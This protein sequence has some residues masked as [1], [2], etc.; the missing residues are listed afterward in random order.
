M[1]K[2]MNLITEEVQV[3]E[4]GYDLETNLISAIIYA[5]LNSR[6]ILDFDYRDMVK[7]QSKVEY[8]TSKNGT[9]KVYSSVYDMISYTE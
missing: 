6:R 9:K 4:N 8:I 5:Y 3:F 1:N 7:E 2:V